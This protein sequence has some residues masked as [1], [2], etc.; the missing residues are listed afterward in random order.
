MKGRFHGSARPAPGLVT[1]HRESTPT[2]IIHPYR[3]S[4]R[5]TRRRGTAHTAPVWIRR[6]SASCADRVPAITLDT[7]APWAAIPCWSGGADEW[8]RTTVTHAY[9]QHYDTLVRPQMPGNPISLE[10]LVKVA[11]ARARFA[12]HRTGRQC[13][14]TNAT[15]AE[16]T[17]VSVRTVQRAST[18]LRLLGVATEVLRGRQRTRAERYASWRVGDSGRG[19]ASV[20][21]LHDLRFRVLSPHPGG[22]S[23]KK[24]PSRKTK[25]TTA[26]R[27][28]GA[29]RGAAKRR[30]NPDGPGLALANRW[31]ND[32][33]SP[34]WARRY[35]TGRPWA[36]IL[37]GPARHGWSPRDIN[38]LITDWIGT[39]HWMP[40]SPHKPIGLLGAIL[41][42]HDNLDERPAAADV[43]RELAELAAARA[44]V[45][46]QIA[47]REQAERAREAGREALNG[48][49][50]A[51]AREALAQI[52]QRA[53]RRRSGG[54]GREH[55]P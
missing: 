19:W 54:C 53:K 43:A 27:R 2:T 34:P 49:G 50:H 37:A 36:R 44:R 46:E 30:P 52:A 13:R 47:R 25:I 24:K 51:A 3:G 29:G 35:H 8:A 55:T 1:T 32:Q 4:S 40:D 28:P 15:L 18:A 38:Q 16:I 20:W 12:D 21:A 31:V 10:T 6:I 42:W 23:V 26:P 9:L 33:Q 48:P 41:A 11:A 45:A 39:G 14:P 17:G 7:E 22:S 5:H